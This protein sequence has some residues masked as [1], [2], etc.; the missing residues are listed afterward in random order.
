MTSLGVQ[1]HGGMGYVEE[2]GAAQHI[3]DA[4]IS[5]IYEGTN[6]IQAADLV[7]RKLSADGGA[8]LRRLLADIRAAAPDESPLA[9]LA[10]DC[11]TRRGKAARRRPGRPARRLL[12]LPH[13]AVGR[14]L[15]LAD[16][17][18]AGGAGR[19]RIRPSPR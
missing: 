7:G 16:A 18:P 14:D 15:R 9:G 4:R 12:S 2:T 19:R 11:E 8:A 6:G 10:E 17:A 1:V 13:D 3:R 5:P